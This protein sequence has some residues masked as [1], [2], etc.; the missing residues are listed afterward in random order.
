MASIFLRPQV[1][2]FVIL[3]VERDGSTYMTTLLQEHPGIEI[4]FERFAVMR[5]KGQSAQ[6]QLAWVNDHWTPALVSKVGAIGFKTKLVDVL[7]LDGFTRLLHGKKVKILYMYRRNRIKAVVS[8]INAKR[9][10]EATGNWNLYKESDRQPPMTVDIAEFHQ[11]VQEREDADNA[12]AAYVESLQLPHMRIQYEDLQMDKD[13]VLKQ[14]FAF[15]G[16]QAATVQGK[17]K[18]HTKDDLREVVV[19][20]DELKASFAG[21]PYFDM[22]DEVVESDD[23]EIENENDE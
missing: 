11:F 2:P 8:R 17:T 9:L 13:S 22:F 1:T 4:I 10:H 19:N 14:V 20:F 3:F 23:G 7:D 16:V 18:K 21:T 15:L 12:L 6:E 5:Q